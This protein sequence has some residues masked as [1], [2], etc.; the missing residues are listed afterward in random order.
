M[1]PGQADIEKARRFVRI[2]RSD[3]SRSV[4]GASDPRHRK[5]RR[6]ALTSAIQ[7][8]IPGVNLSV[9]RAAAPDGNDA[10]RL[11]QVPRERASGR[12]WRRG[13]SIVIDGR[14]N[15][16]RPALVCC[17]LAESRRTIV[18]ARH[19]H[20]LPLSCRKGRRVDPTGRHRRSAR[21]VS[22]RARDAGID[23]TVI[24]ATFSDGY[25]HANRE[26]AR[27]VARHPRRLLGF[28]FIHPLADKGRV[29]AMIREAVANS[30]SSA[31]R[32]IATTPG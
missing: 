23:R 31:S 5:S 13:N 25:L 29:D 14:V 27:I 6:S 12:W 15:D 10:I 19:D 28:A 4:V 18:K 3:R 21:Q 7:R 32:S 1:D 20:R 8:N 9:L 17:G 2:A 30:G 26:V 22:R 16:S 24:F 11:R